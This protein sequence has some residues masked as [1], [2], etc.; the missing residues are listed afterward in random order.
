MARGQIDY[1]PA[2]DYRAFCERMNCMNVQQIL[3][4]EL[5]KVL[6]DA[7]GS[8]IGS[9]L[10]EF[11]DMQIERAKDELKA[12]IDAELAKISKPPAA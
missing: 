2:F 9:A 10:K 12:F 3:K 5:A 11:F 4:D 6:E 8:Q 1:N 7:E